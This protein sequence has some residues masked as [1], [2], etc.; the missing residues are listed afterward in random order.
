LYGWAGTILRID[1]SRGKIVKEPLN[2]AFAKAFIGGR[3]FNSKILYDEFDPTITDP[4]SPENIICIGAGPLSGTAPATG[5][6]VV[7]AARTPLTGVFGDG[8][9][10]GFFAPEMAYAGY[11]VIVVKGRAPVLSTI[12]IQDDNVEIRKSEEMK[13]KTV[14]ETYEMVREEMGDPEAQ[15]LAIG[16]AGERLV[17]VSIALHGYRAPGTVGLG[18]IFGSK[19]LKAICVRGTRS[20]EIAK[21][22]EFEK[23]FYEVLDQIKT[24]PMYETWAMYG[25]KIITDW[26]GEQGLDESKNFREIS[27]ESEWKRLSATEY[28]KKYQ[29][30]SISCFNCPVHCN[31]VYFIREGPYAGTIGGKL[32]F[33]TVHSLGAQCGIFD[34]GAVAYLNAICTSLG[35]GTG[36]AAHAIYTAMDWWEEG[37]IDS[38]D[39][40]GLIL[41]WGNVE[42]VATLLKQMAYKE[43]FG[44]ILGEGTYR[45]AEILAAK[46]GLPLEKFESRIMG[47]KKKYMHISYRFSPYSALAHATATR[48]PDHLRGTFGARPT[49][50]PFGLKGLEQLSKATGVPLEI[51]KEWAA[52][53]LIGADKLMRYEGVA[54]VLKFHEDV[55]AVCDCLVMCRFASPWRFG[56]GPVLMAK[57]LSAVTGVEYDWKEVMQCGERIYTVEYA[58]QRRF[59]WRRID[60]HPPERAFK[61]PIPS[62]PHKGKV[63]DR[64]KYEKMLD[65]YYEVR[66]YDKEGIPTLE[67][68]QRLGLQDIADDL[69]KRNILK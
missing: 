65:E 64:E 41:E 26:H 27:K 29:T 13:D 28:L 1:L 55:Y 16:P 49:V 54:Q 67:T 21:P 30:R 66:G 20:K 31:S 8:N 38:K 48:G 25:T 62:G 32:E 46:K 39:T 5:R 23:L 4:F 24:H 58:M 69:K 45:A 61:E 50:I 68:L 40:G 43:G 34:M 63:L 22:D 36:A 59:G 9:C 18:A 2:K 53:D 56:V 57:L 15:V 33:H 7:S 52:H 35:L 37:L 14:W 42:V 10:G 19:N 17:R 12:L 6:L 3:G 11:D 47:S 60:D 44:A 51:L